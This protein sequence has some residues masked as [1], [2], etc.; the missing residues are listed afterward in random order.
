MHKTSIGLA[1]KGKIYVVEPVKILLIEIFYFVHNHNFKELNNTSKSLYC[2]TSTVLMSRV[3]AP[4]CRPLG[5]H[6]NHPFGTPTCPPK[7]KRRSSVTAHMSGHFSSRIIPRGRLDAADVASAPQTA[8]SVI[9]LGSGTK[10]KFF[11]P[12]FVR[13]PRADINRHGQSSKNFRFAGFPP[14]CESRPTSDVFSDPGE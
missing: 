13:E 9:R 14:F 5:A 7:V 1:S 12:A 4:A 10:N 2:R 6:K 8:A 11:L 3:P